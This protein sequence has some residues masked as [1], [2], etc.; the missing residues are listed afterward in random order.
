MRVVNS[1]GPGPWSGVVS[2]RTPQKTTGPL[3]VGPN[4]NY[5]QGVPILTWRSI[6]GVEDLVSSY[7]VE[8][9]SQSNPRFR[10]HSSGSVSL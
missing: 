6:E 3:I 4:V 5:R 9:M 2:T 7:K 8:F 10:P 1:A